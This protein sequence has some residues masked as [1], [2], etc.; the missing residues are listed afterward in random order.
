MRNKY[1]T[2]EH[3][4][5]DDAPVLEGCLQ[6][7]WWKTYAEGYMAVGRDDAVKS[8][9]GRCLLTVPDLGLWY[10]SLR[11]PTR[12]GKHDVIMMYGAGGVTSPTSDGPAKGRVQKGEMT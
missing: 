8:I 5:S 4:F 6:G 2:P 9:F 10:D 7:S 3:A 11:R 1:G 12:T